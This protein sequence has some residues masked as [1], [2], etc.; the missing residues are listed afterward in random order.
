MQ[1]EFIKTAKDYGVLTD[2][3]YNPDIPAAIMNTSGTT[4]TPKEQWNLIKDIM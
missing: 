1:S 3:L 2:S 4:G